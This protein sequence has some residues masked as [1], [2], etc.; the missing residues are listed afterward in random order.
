[1][2]HGSGTVEPVYPLVTDPPELELELELVPEPELEPELC[3]AAACD[4]L[5][6]DFVTREPE[7]A[8]AYQVPPKPLTPCP[9]TSP[10]LLSPEKRYRGC[11]W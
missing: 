4:E 1:V 7:G 10:D 8:S 9:F 3:P 11:S 6:A 2:P 5:I